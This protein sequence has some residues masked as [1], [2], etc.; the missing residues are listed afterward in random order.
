MSVP[1]I[2]LPNPLGPSGHDPCTI[3]N[4]STAMERPGGCAGVHCKP[5]KL[6]G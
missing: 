6:G 1:R 3:M 5:S 2:T 4:G